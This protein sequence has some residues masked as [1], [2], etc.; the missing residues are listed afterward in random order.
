MRTSTFR[1]INNLGMCEDLNYFVG[2]HNEI[3][4]HACFR[5]PVVTESTDTLRL[6]NMSATFE[7]L[8]VC[9]EFSSF[10]SYFVLVITLLL[11]FKT[12]EACLPV[13]LA[14]A[15]PVRSS[16]GSQLQS[17][18]DLHTPRLGMKTENP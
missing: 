17:Q 9:C 10:T 5:I 12:M 18:L 1:N 7:L 2:K 11:P 15:L 6:S 16:R 13:L 14:L 4:Y 8:F 3:E